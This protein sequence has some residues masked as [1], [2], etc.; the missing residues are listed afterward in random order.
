MNNINHRNLTHYCM[1]HLPL[2]LCL[3]WSQR[4]FQLLTVW[5]S[6]S[7][8]TACG[9]M[10]IIL[11]VKGSAY[12]TINKP[13]KSSFCWLDLKMGCVQHQIAPLRTLRVGSC[14]T[15]TCFFSFFPGI[16]SWIRP[17]EI[18]SGLQRGKHSSLWCS[19]R[20]AEH[21]SNRLRVKRP[22]AFLIKD[23]I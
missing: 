9:L 14:S 20:S 23:K 12:G 22:H 5:L 8:S 13:Q 3:H 11:Y 18:E 16:L 19:L 2:P 6:K 17:R 1:M 21:S 7:L 4:P 15:P 10:N